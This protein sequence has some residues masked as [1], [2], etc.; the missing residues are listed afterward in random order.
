MHRLAIGLAVFVCPLFIVSSAQAQRPRA[1]AFKQVMRNAKTLYKRGSMRPD[2][3]KALAKQAKLLHR[4][5]LARGPQARF[6]RFQLETLGDVVG[7]TVADRGRVS[8]GF[9]RGVPRPGQIQIHE[10]QLTF[11]AGGATLGQS[12][13]GQILSQHRTMDHVTTKWN[14]FSTKGSQ[15]FKAPAP[16]AQ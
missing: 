16:P 11:R 15:T 4:G 12:S 1:A 14:L 2:Q 5:T 6:A 9:T 8:G 3:V 10:S 7:R 13:K